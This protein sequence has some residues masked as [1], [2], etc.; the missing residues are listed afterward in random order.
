MQSLG[1]LLKKIKKDKVNE[2]DRRE[3]GG[4]PS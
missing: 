2:L 3:L 4:R 1:A